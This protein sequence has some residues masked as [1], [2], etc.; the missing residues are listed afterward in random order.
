MSIIVG[1]EA[2]PTSIAPALD[3]RVRRSRS[4]L[5]SAAID[6][7]SRRETAAVP[8]SEIA[9]TA[10]VSRQVVYQQFGNRDVLL[11]EA[12]LDLLRRELLPGLS[13]LPD[14]PDLH[15]TAAA[16]VGHFA[17]HRPFYRAILTSSCAFGVN[18]A[19]T[20]FFLPH[21]RDAVRL[22]WGGDLAPQEIED[23][24][25]FLTGGW[26]T[27][28]NTWVV[29]GD[30]PLDVETFADRLV[31]TVSAIIGSIGPSIAAGKEH[32]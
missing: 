29:E 13:E 21:N 31:R 16:V 23:L 2:E 32:G 28:I 17:D 30:D 8:L 4:S 27:L 15:A 12:A 14:N 6:L 10:D 20:R 9:E 5:I 19:L 18:Q 11:L 1:V 25:A 26:A 3:R 24:A 22:L 7:V